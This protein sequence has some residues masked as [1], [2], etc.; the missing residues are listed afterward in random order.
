[1]LAAMDL[2]LGLAQ[3]GPFA[4]L[5]SVVKIAKGAE[6]L[7]YDGLWVGDRLLT[8]LAPK[9]RYPGGEIP[10]RHGTFLDPFLVLSVAA[11]VTGRVRLGTSAVNACWYPPPLLARSFATL[12]RMSGGRAI[13]GFGLGWSS[14][15]YAA[16]GVPWRGRAARLDDA[17]DALAAIWSPGPVAYESELWTIAPSVIEPKP[18]NLPVYLAGLARPALDRVARR[19]DG[20]L[21]VPLPVPVLT[22]M[23]AHIRQAAE[24]AGRDPGQIRMVLRCNPEVTE[25]PAAPERV[26]RAGTVAQIAGYLTAAAEAGAHEILIDL[27]LTAA[28]DDELLALAGSFRDALR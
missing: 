12:D 8:P 11:S 27:Q 10:A 5:D 25:S 18:V 3:Y 7:G 28:D 22:G 9:D 4:T 26:P 19:A 17:L 1:M 20:W 15:E 21:T 6:E 23:W 24:R 2:G 14:D 16:N 13:A